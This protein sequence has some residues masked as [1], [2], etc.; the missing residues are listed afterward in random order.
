M[1]R[2]LLDTHVFL[3]TLASQ[4]RLRDS[5]RKEI[6]DAGNQVFISS[7]AV[8]EIAI[9]HARGRM[10]GL[11]IPFPTL[12]GAIATLGFKELPF[13]GAH[14]VATR[15]LPKHHADP[16]DRAMIAQALAEDLTLVTAD[17]RVLKYPVHSLRAR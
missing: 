4:S 9:K 5:V 16:F 7:I 13:K 17:K 2:L 12:V 15:E 6:A 11:T 3:W 10:P 14:A 1:K 8:W